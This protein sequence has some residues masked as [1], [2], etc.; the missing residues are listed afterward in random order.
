MSIA[1]V[2]HIRED[3]LARGEIVGDVEVVDSGESRRVRGTADLLSTPGVSD[4]NVGPG[5]VLPNLAVVQLD[6]TGDAKNGDVTLFN[7]VGEVNSA[8]DIEGWF[9]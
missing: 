1:V 9:Q 2:I 8:L 5:E 6:T 7:S 4:L 3:G